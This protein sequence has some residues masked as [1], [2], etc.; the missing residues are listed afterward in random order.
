MKGKRCVGGGKRCVG[1]GKRCAG[2]FST[3]ISW[4]IARKGSVY[5]H[6]EKFYP[7]NWPIDEFLRSI[8]TPSTLIAQNDFIQ[9]SFQRFYPANWPIGLFFFDINASF[10]QKCR[11]SEAEG[12]GIQWLV[13]EPLSAMMNSLKFI[14]CFVESTSVLFVFFCCVFI[15]LFTF[16]CFRSFFGGK[17]VKK[18]AKQRNLSEKKC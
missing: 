11:K 2:T 17:I 6:N 9:R 14:N 10:R 13:E 12:G 1:G 7:A 5:R 16:F 15:S 18:S 3:F 4:L 8:W